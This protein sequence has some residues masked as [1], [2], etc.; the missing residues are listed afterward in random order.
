[1]NPRI[2]QPLP[3]SNPPA[4][5]TAPPAK[6]GGGFTTMAD[7]AAAAGNAGT[8]SLPKPRKLGGMV[9]LVVVA[10]IAAGLLLGMRKLGMTRRIEMVDFKIDYP[11]EKAELQ[12]L[13]K[14]HEEVLT[15]LK[16]SGEL[17]Q[18]PLEKVQTDPFEWKLSEKKVQRDT[19]D[20][21]ALEAELARKAAEDR[22]RDLEN[23]A[24]RMKLNGVMGGRVP[25][26]NIGGTLVKVGDL[27]DET[28]TVKSIEGRTVI[29]EADGK[30]FT[31]S[32]GESSAP[33]K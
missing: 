14:D 8:Q 3:G 5:G 23:R 9:M 11:I 30:E 13:S 2:M 32:I 19:Q 12:R 15:E 7:V 4:A 28:F 25:V 6:A 10:L 27:V 21:A 16:A 22:K 29:V 24:A 1:M 18:V 31:I 26:A 17:V 20:D 33:K